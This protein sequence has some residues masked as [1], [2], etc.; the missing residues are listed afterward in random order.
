[1]CN[2]EAK[3]NHLENLLDGNNNHANAQISYKRIPPTEKQGKQLK[4]DLNE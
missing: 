1:M 4:I 3:R 2:T